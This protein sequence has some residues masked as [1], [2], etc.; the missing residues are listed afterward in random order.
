MEQIIKIKACKDDGALLGDFTISKEVLDDS[1]LA[2][3]LLESEDFNKELKINDNITLINVPRVDKF[4]DITPIQY[5]KNTTNEANILLLEENEYKINF[6]SKIDDIEIFYSLLNGGF[7]ESPLNLFN[8]YGGFL[9]FKSYAGKTF[10]DIFDNGEVVFSV[11]IEVRSKKIN[12]NEQYP[13]MIGDLSKYSSGLI[14]EVNSPLYQSFELN[15]NKRETN[16]EDFMLLEYLF[17]EENLPSTFEYLSRNLYSTLENTVE[18]VP[19]SLAANIGPNELINMA[20]NPEHLYKDVNSN[21]MFSKKM[22]GFVP[23]KVDQITYIDTI[24]VPENRFYKNF[25][26]SIANLINNLLKKSDN[27]YVKDKLLEYKEQISYYLSQRYFRDISRMDY[28]PLNSQVLQKKEG[29]RDILQYFL[30]FEFGF[31]LTWNQITDEFKGYEK[32]LYDLYEYWCYFELINV[33]KDLTD[34][35]INF[36]N[37]FSIDSS[38]WSISLKEGVIK[39]FLLTMDDKDIILKLM[40]NKTFNKRSK[41]FKSYSVDLRPDY[42]LEVEFDEDIY[43]IHFDAKYKVD[44]ANDEKYKNQDIYKMHTYKDAIKNTIGAY[45][46]YPGKK[47]KL[48]YEDKENKLESVGAFPLNPGED[49]EEKRELTEF[50]YGLI[51]DLI[52]S[53]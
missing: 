52:N 17:R 4:D 15:D 28:A 36:E 38:N 44:F 22:R 27:G 10:L 26:E 39:E 6:D 42:T 20:S 3:S 25:L 9:N 31:K 50:I 2:N 11:P 47:P 35:K 33:V 43:R 46:L 8:K 13:A 30:M 37:V 14:F 1:Y 21:I 48:F 19:T 24:D 16:Y 12:Y 29:Y 45:V 49:K 51:S 53:N 40:Y 7:D 41:D 34:S 18:T 23:V 5:Y 32:K